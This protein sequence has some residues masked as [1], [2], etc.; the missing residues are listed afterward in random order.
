MKNQKEIKKIIKQI[1]KSYKP[2]QV[3]LFGSFAYGKTKL[4]SDIDL[5]II[6]KTKKRKIER[7]KEVLMKVE[8]NFPLEPLVYS[9]E[10]LQERLE[11]GDFFF[12]DI[13]KKGKVVYAK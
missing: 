4:S 3:V 11:M 6:K 5:L 12:Q 1:V 8:S 2:E 10:E 9:P 7:I 13:M